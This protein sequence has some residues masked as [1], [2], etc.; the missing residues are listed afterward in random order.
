MSL[1][2]LPYSHFLPY[3]HHHS[4]SHHYH[5]P[6]YHYQNHNHNHDHRYL[7]C[8]L[9]TTAFFP[10]SAA[11]SYDLSASPSQSQSTHSLGSNPAFTMNNTLSTDEMERFQQLSNEFEADVQVSLLSDITRWMVNADGQG[12]LVSTKQS[13]QAIATEYAN[14]DPAFATKSNVCFVYVSVLY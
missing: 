4:P 3:H 2:D 7:D 8:G 14:A 9:Y 10:V 5:H 11:L 1:S 13:T 12:P 6:N